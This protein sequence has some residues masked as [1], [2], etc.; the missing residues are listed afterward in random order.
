[1]GNDPN[2]Y[3]VPTIQRLDAADWLPRPVHIARYV[4][5]EPYFGHLWGNQFSFNFKSENRDF[6]AGVCFIY[7]YREFQIGDELGE[8]LSDNVGH[9]EPLQFDVK[10]KT[11]KLIALWISRM[12]TSIWVNF[13]ALYKDID[14]KN[15]GSIS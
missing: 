15:H 12:N 9:F 5:L 6:I 1:M 8:L 11:P 10:L 2:Q 7:Q 13:V 14:R 4:V 3:K